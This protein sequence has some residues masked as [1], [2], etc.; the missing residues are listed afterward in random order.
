MITSDV[1]GRLA[2]AEVLITRAI[3]HKRRRCS[4]YE[5]KRDLLRCYTVLII[6]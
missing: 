6:E 5:A 4:H 2:G 1:R 3:L